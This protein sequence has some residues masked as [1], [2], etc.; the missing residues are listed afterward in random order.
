[1]EQTSHR[2]FF[3]NVGDHIYLL[4]FLL[5]MSSSSDG[6]R[7]TGRKKKHERTNGIT[8][9]QHGMFG[10]LVTVSVCVIHRETAVMSLMT[11]WSPGRP[12][13][14]RKGW[15]GTD[16]SYQTASTRTSQ[17]TVFQDH[18]PCQPIGAPRCWPLPP[19]PRPPLPHPVW[20]A[21]ARPAPSHLPSYQG[22]QKHRRVRG[23]AGHGTADVKVASKASRTS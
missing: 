11:R 17:R 9:Q 5:R 6:L 12:G 20:L 15:A 10:W 2:I 1:M 8:S 21:V 3:L 13:A 7:Q 22:P 14:A 23:A 16:R 18:S 19:P 4:I